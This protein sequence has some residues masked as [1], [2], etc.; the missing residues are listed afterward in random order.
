MFT[1]P[2]DQQAIFQPTHHRFCLHGAAVELTCA[3]PDLR[4]EIRA[5]FGA[6]ALQ[7]A[8]PHSPCV[9]TV[10]PYDQEEVVRRVSASAHLVARTAEMAEVY[11]DG[12][13][14]WLVD[15]RWGL[16]ELNLLKNTWRSW[17]I[18]APELDPFR[19]M[20]M[21]VIW[22]LAHL[23]RGRGLH[24]TPAVSVV[25]QG[26]GTLLIGPFGLEPE[27]IAMRDAGYRLIGQRW[28]V[29]RDAENEV[30]LL[31]VPGGVERSDVPR[32]PTNSAKEGRWI[33]LTEGR[34]DAS[35]ERAPCQKILVVKHGR[36]P[37]A[38]LRETDAT[39]TAKLLR[40]T[41]PIPELYPQRKVAPL[42]SRL[43]QVARCWD[44]QLSRNPQDL[45]G[46]LRAGSL[47]VTAV[48]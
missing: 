6:F 41:W 9:G 21:A 31:N 13:R 35:A 20:E 19:C 29:L 45:L 39:A 40:R 48:A 37:N 2:S 44:V 26:S 17:V 14:F 42:A 1:G 27:L 24:L 25:Y 8:D 16:C 18:P 22:P 15:D 11:R 38:H 12:H 33:D 5:I 36:R 46:I 30:L 7:E 10:V 34:A 23:L 4:R 3:V 43:A 28:T 32:R 47:P